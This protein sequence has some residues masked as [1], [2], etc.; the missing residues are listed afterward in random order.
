M[1]T[2]REGPG[3][4]ALD[5]TPLGDGPWVTLEFEKGQVRVLRY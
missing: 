3:S 4:D 2:G 1:D 5:G